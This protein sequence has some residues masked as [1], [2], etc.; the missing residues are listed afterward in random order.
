MSGF[1]GKCG[2]CL[3]ILRKPAGSRRLTDLAIAAAAGAFLLAAASPSLG[4]V[5]V[6]EGRKIDLAKSGEPSQNEMRAAYR[7]PQSIPFPAE[8]PYTFEKFILGKALYFDSRLSQ[9]NLLSCASCHSPGYGWGDGQPLGVGHLM[10][11]LGRR[12]PTI[13]NAAY[14]QIFMWDGR[15]ENLEEQALGPI[16]SDA[17]MAQPL[18]DLIKRLKQIREYP[19][20]FQ[21]AFPDQ[22][23][24]T[25]SIA[26]A[27]ATY[28][29]TVISARAPFDAWIEGDEK[30]I[31]DDAK[32][33]FVL[34]NTKARC[35]ACHSG[36]NFTDDSFH[37]IGLASQDIGRGKFLTNVVK[38][39]FAF[40]TPGLREISRRAPFMH[41][42]SI[43]TLEAVVDHYDAGGVERPSRSDLIG[44]LHLSPKEK[45]DLVAFLKTLNSG[46][47]P[48]VMPVLPR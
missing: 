11:R 35:N 9:G 29:R 3:G 42:G 6:G 32:Q 21:A 19:P 18:D 39:K 28:E 14:G 2:D 8:N 12:S 48:T 33:G 26:K 43:A 30:A 44:P 4:D 38:S 5:T 16:Q 7:R 25:G 23:M 1:W 34:F 10:K 17:E 20:L 15:A 27:I 47:D 45:A 24:T 40:K 36:W 46:P 37:D 41:D 13:V 22:E 31:P